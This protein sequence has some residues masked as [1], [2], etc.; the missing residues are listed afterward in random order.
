MPSINI[1][2]TRDALEPS[3]LRSVVREL[4][5]EFLDCHGGARTRD[6]RSLTV[7]ARVIEVDADK[8]FI[9]GDVAEKP[10]YEIEFVT[11][12]KVLEAETKRR[13]AKRA[14]EILRRADSYPSSEEDDRIWCFFR[15]IADGDWASGGTIYTSREV[16]R[17][18]ARRAQEKRQRKD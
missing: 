3:V 15:E 2:L 10:R 8:Y 14:A 1:T 7:S 11:F 5:D 18:L 9:C 6:L 13:L 12:P 16:V 4:I 17:W